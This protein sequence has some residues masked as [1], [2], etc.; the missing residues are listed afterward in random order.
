[1]TQSN[2]LA[3]AKAAYDGFFN[4]TMEPLFSMLADD[5]VWTNHSAAEYSP[6][7]GI[8]KGV[9][10]VKEYF[11]HMPEIDQL[12]FEILVDTALFVRFWSFWSTWPHTATHWLGLFFVVLVEVGGEGWQGYERA[13]GK[14]CSELRPVCTNQYH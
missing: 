13:S 3:L 2:P 9:K 8:H 7:T 5:V 11:S 12:K 1:M 10:G 6:F 4:G 14:P